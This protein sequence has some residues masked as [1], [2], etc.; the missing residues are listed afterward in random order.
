MTQ[1]GSSG[2]PIGPSLPGSSVVN[3]LVTCQSPSNRGGGSLLFKGN[4]CLRMILLAQDLKQSM[5]T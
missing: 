2:L 4:K 1:H 5:G 3:E